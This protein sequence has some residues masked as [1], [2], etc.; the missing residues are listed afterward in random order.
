MILTDLNT[1]IQKRS[2]NNEGF[3]DMYIDMRYKEKRILSDCKVMFLPEIE[4]DHIHYKEWQI[5]KQ[6]AQRLMDYLKEINKPLNI[7][8]IGCGNGWLSA[9]L[10]FLNGAKV[11][12]ID[13]N[14]PEIQQ[15][16]RVFKSDNLEFICTAFDAS[17]YQE[18]K[19]DIILFAAS[20]QYFKSLKEIIMSALCCLKHNGEIHITDTNF[21]TPVAAMKAVIRSEAYFASIGFPEMAGYY[22]HH[23]F[24]QLREFNYKVLYNPHRIIN[25]IT[26]KNPFYWIVIKH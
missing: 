17:V 4:E 3:A 1:G 24:K 16:Q 21:Y 10:C 9:K 2:Y 26:K 5:R 22:F 23:S 11:T 18:Q 13:I 20:I 12:G 8:E 19:F 15:A 14:E 7:L 25:K 6:S